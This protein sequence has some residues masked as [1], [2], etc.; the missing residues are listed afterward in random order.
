MGPEKLLCLITDI[1]EVGV[2]GFWSVSLHSNNT[3]QQKRLTPGVPFLSLAV[4]WN[5][6]LSI[7]TQ[8]A[9]VACWKTFSQYFPLEYLNF[10]ATSVSDNV[11]QNLT[12]DHHIF[13]KHG[14]FIDIPIFP[15]FPSIS[16]CWLYISVHNIHCIPMKWR[17]LYHSSLWLSSTHFQISDT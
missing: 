16:Y 13:E 17:V 3:H 6:F 11:R 2:H 10:C 5:R 9:R 4:D 1:W 14:K 8:Q 12:F 7:V 15:T